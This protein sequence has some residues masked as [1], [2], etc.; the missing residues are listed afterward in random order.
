M[1]TTSQD[2]NV[3]LGVWQEV[4]AG[5]GAEH[6]AGSRGRGGSH[7]GLS[8]PEAKVMVLPQD[9]PGSRVLSQGLTGSGG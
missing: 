5:G 3:L 6:A 2:Q 7:S 8:E 9:S 4:G 1:L